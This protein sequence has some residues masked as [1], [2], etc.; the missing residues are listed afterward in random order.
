MISEGH[1]KDDLAN[2]AGSV[3]VNGF[4][5]ALLKNARYKHIRAYGVQDRKNATINLKIK[6]YLNFYQR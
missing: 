5:L 3:A 4:T 1:A 6:K 2:K